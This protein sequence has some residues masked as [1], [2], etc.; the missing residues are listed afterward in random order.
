M[1]SGTLTIYSASAGSG[2]TYK[3][4]G[5]FLAKLF[6]SRYG[7]RKILAVTFTN[8]AT[9]EMKNRILDQ[10]YTLSSGNPSTYL[11][12]LIKITSK[13]ESEIR[14]EAK[15]ILDAVLNDFS[16]FSV[17]T[18]DSFFQK[19]IR[20][21]ARDIGLYSGFE[22]EIDHSKVLSLAVDEMIASA[23]ENVTVRKWLIDYAR[24]NISDGRSWNLKNEI[25]KLAGELFNEHFK[26]LSSAEKLKLEDKEFLISYLKEL[27]AISSTFE[28]SLKDLGRR[29]LTLWT[30]YGLTDDMFFQ[31]GKGIPSFIRSLSAGEIKA[32]NRYV[33]DIFTEP[34][35][36]CTGKM[37]ELLQQAIKSGLE[38][39][40]KEAVIYY[41]T[42]IL[43][44]K[45]AVTIRSNIFSLGILSDVLTH[46][47]KINA[48]ENNF[49]LSDAGEMLYMITS[50]DQAPFIYEKV[51][52]RFENFMID[53]FQDTSIIQWNN[54][55]LLIENSMAEGFDNV[56]VG[57]IKQSIYR[58]RNSDWRILGDLLRNE[59]QNNRIRSIPLTTNWRSR[60]NIISFNNRI[61]SSIPSRLDQDFVNENL[62]V[63][64]TELFAEAVQNDPGKKEGGYI[65]LEFIEEKEDEQWR[66]IVLQRL[67]SVIENL[68][69]RGY[70]PS[71]I[72][73][74][75]RDN[76]EG[77]VVLKTI[78]DYSNLCPD[79][80]R[81]TYNFDVISNDSLLLSQSYCINF[82]IATLN[83]LNDSSDMINTARM[84]RFF[85]LASG[86]DDAE[87]AELISPALKDGMKRYFPEGYDSFL[88]SLLQLP[89]FEISES[90]IRFFGLGKWSWNVA[91]LNTFQDH[92]LGFSKSKSADIHS[93]LDW[94]ETDGKKKSVVLPEHL[95]AIRVM[96]V[97]K[98]KGLEFKA[99]IIP[100]LSWNL[101]HKPL[102]Q[103]ILWVKPNIEPF[104]NLGIVPVKYKKELEETIFRDDYKYE[105]YSA[106][107]DNLNLLYVSF[108]RSVDVL[109]G[110]LPDD[111]KTENSIAR[112]IS[113]AVKSDS[114]PDTVATINLKTFYDPEKNIFEYGVIPLNISTPSQE[115][116]ITSI[117]YFINQDMESLKL[118]LHGENY[119][120]SE[121]GGRREKIN[122][123]RLMHEV[124]ENIITIGDIKPAVKRMVKR[125]LI[126]ELEAL[127]FEQ[128]L[129]ELIV[130]PGVAEW[131]RPDNKVMTETG[132]LLP[133]GELKRPDRVVFREG[134]TT[135][136]D[137][138]FGAENSHYSK[139]IA[140][141]CKYI[142]GMGFTNVVGY[143]WYVDNN[144]TVEV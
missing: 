51:G 134:K 48:A 100:F 135:V 138:K 84:L 140:A 57:D 98:S 15:V 66:N 12:E 60:T 143:I 50:N 85:L 38:E 97:H 22:T 44:Y 90:I 127:Q 116:S 52:N 106:L 1:Q 70:K 3:L 126:D 103:N 19:I 92:I 59:T 10:L 61:F 80:K 141:Y 121:A 16:R 118:K 17:S 115:D 76:R 94:W 110:F 62:P 47:R 35:K 40:L 87:K 30:D 114:L 8:K 125:G 49:L 104:N 29:C 31:K 37:S 58:W 34:P 72:G 86:V 67:P 74:L 144:K 24:S 42:H 109:I 142:E 2:K 102:Q 20:A 68:Q 123:G 93:F 119:F 56:V 139:Q 18:I 11:E 21:F 136:I 75:V 107:L 78:T 128:K 6:S 131:F 14:A 55:R 43:N 117:T 32:P 79:D 65:R 96:T 25:V 33:R 129:E 105:K 88:S 99:V 95:N 45:T 71:D 4:T 69:D 36:W 13:S 130:S 23:S 26:L 63:K 120:L 81:K 124:F 82:I 83:V 132:I 111:P 133:G 54:F 89:L 28:K 101:D 73:I 64:F 91:Y 39:K 7:Y 9:A 46:V 41:D 112:V 77:S 137:F 53:E 27:N 122:Y 113:N 108:T 5:L